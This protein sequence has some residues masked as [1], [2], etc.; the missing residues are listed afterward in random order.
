MI[1]AELFILCKLFIPNEV[2]WAWIILFILTDWS[3]WA[4]LKT[5]LQ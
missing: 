3:M 4:G 1:T 2:H 5:V